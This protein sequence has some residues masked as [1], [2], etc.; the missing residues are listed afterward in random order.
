[1]TAVEP[2]ATS[3]AAALGYGA[4]VN[5]L[6]AAFDSRLTRPLAWRSAQLRQLVRLLTENE[7]E[8]LAALATDL[9]KPTIEAYATDIGFSAMEIKG[10]IKNL[11]RW[12][13]DTKVRLPLTAM[14]GRGRIVHQPLGVA[15]VIAPWNYPIQLLLVPVAC[16]I[17]AGCAVVAKPSELAPATSAAMGRLIPRYLDARAVAVVEGGVPETAALLKERWDTI[18]YTGNGTV[19]RVVARAAAEHLTPVTL[20]LGGKSP[21]IVD[22]DADL[23]VAARRISWGKFLNAGQTCIAPDHV[24][25]HEA[26]A[27]ELIDRIVS[28]IGDLYGNDAR[29]S[30]DYAR[31]I[32][33]R[34]FARLGRLIDGAG[35]SGVAAH[36]VTGGV[37][38]PRDRYLA[39]TVLTDIADDAP[40]MAEEIFGPVLPIIPVRDVEDAIARVNAG[41]KPLALYAFSRNDHTLQRIVDHTSSGGV[42][43]NHVVMHVTAP[44]LPFGG[45]GE[46]GTGSYHG[47]CGIEAF[48]H[49]RSVMSKPTSP[50]PSIMYPPYTAIKRWV[51]RKAF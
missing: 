43:L 2:A 8:L 22:R 40:C 18:F 42:C 41:D 30:P 24:L 47:R 23:N 29:T 28:T 39:P 21:V 19:G 9:G 32:N 34:H 10:L 27:D 49:R 16:A 38:D 26:V 33:S 17:A 46:S 12:T 5:E 1:M 25:V 45:V 50:D 51:M 48:S 6:R 44:S 7:P 20:E 14:P 3:D 35:P 11:E 31:I 13:A 36:V 37:R 4:L 15:L